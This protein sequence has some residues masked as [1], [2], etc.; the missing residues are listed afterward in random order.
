MPEDYI[1]PVIME[2]VF[3]KLPGH[4][5]ESDL[6]EITSAKTGDLLAWTYIGYDD[7]VQTLADILSS[8]GLSRDANRLRSMVQEMRKV[9]R[10]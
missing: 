3:R 1:S 8:K 10:A 7:G 5:E 4:D 2:R 6:V 9:K